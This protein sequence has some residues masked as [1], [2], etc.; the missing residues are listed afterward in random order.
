MKKIELWFDENEI[1]EFMA[2]FSMQEA[3][4]QYGLD[5]IK[6]IKQNG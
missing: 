1:D 6:D 4:V 3:K 5:W 2:L